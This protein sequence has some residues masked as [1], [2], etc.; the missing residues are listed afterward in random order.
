[1]NRIYQIQLDEISKEYKTALANRNF[2]KAEILNNIIY[3]IEFD[4]YLELIDRRSEWLSLGGG[5]WFNKEAIAE[6][7]DGLKNL[8]RVGLKIAD[9][10]NKELQS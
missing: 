6:A 1:M 9:S 3:K 4:K 5:G 8:L 7:V 2:E 10:K